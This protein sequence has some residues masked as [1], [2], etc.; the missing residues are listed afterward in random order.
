MLQ[1][2]LETFYQIEDEND[3]LKATLDRLNYENTGLKRGNTELKSNTFYILFHKKSWLAFL[4]VESK[5]QQMTN[6]GEEFQR[7]INDLVNERHKLQIECQ[8]LLSKLNAQQEETAKTN[9]KSR[10]KRPKAPTEDVALLSAEIESL[11]LQVAS[12]EQKIDQL[13]N[14]LS[15]ENSSNSYF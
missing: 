10:S 3:E 8:D 6:Q 11:K 15:A 2:K 12:G 4:D 5:D 1:K 13:V 14:E 7:Q 9:K